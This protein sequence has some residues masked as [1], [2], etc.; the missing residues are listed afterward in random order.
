M[1]TFVDMALLTRLLSSLIPADG[2]RFDPIKTSSRDTLIPYIL[3]AMRDEMI[4]SSDG[5][6]GLF[7]PRHCSIKTH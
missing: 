6:V 1:S 4:Y 7:E 5:G 3:I 2:K